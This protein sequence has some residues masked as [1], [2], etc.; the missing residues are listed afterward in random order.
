MLA[1]RGFIKI[2][3]SQ[4]RR[5]ARES[6]A[7]AGA[8]SSDSRILCLIRTD[9]P[10]DAH[11]AIKCPSVP[12]RLFA[13]VGLLTNNPSYSIALSLSKLGRLLRKFEPVREHSR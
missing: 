3:R 2:R 11:S 12:L 13:D 4:P 9:G 10:S 1:I 6:V 7:W 5:P 8:G